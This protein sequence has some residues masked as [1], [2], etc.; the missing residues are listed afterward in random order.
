MYVYVVMYIIIQDKLLD[1]D[2]VSHMYKLTS[3]TGC[4]MTGM[5]G[6]L[7]DFII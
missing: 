1:P 6:E 2:S 7:Y 4:V 5:V 3:N